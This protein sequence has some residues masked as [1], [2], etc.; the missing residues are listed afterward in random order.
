MNYQII[1]DEKALKDFIDWLPELESHETYYCCLFARSKYTKDENGINGLPHI[2]SDKAQLKRF[3]SN[4]ERLFS[5][6]KQLEC[7]VDSYMQGELIVPQQALALYITPNPRSMWKATKNS[8]IH[9]ATCIAN[10]NKNMNPHQEILSEIQKS[11]SRTCFVDFDIDEKFEGNASVHI[12]ELLVDKINYEAY[13]ILET[14]GGY[15]ILVNPKRIDEPY[16][17]IW[18]QSIHKLFPVDQSGDQ[19]IP[20]PGTYQGGFTPRFI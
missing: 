19:M 16:R 3:T 18:R 4:K 11:K 7:P 5:K 2:K 10:E 1:T 8:L 12:S 17:R 14:R 13:D 6:I 20:V 9:L 15:H